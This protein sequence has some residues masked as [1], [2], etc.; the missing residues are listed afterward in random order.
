[1]KAFAII[2]FLVIPFF[3]KSQT[4]LVGEWKGHHP[5]KILHYKGE[6]KDTSPSADSIVMIFVFDKNKTGYLKTQDYQ[7]HP[8]KITVAKFTY[9]LN[10]SSHISMTFSKRVYKKIK[11]EI[12]GDNLRFI[13]TKKEALSA[14]INLIYE[15]RY[16]RMK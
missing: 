11:F 14:S 13:P 4:G 10:D 3:A 12:N 16:R 6:P 15:M 1:M 9:T 2:I 7:S 8:Y 5:E